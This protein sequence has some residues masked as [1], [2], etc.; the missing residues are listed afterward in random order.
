M[1]G[2][3]IPL[4]KNKIFKGTKGLYLDLVAFPMKQRSESKD[5][6]L[7]K[8]SF[9]KEEREKMSREELESLP[10]IGNMTDWNYVQ[11]GNTDPDLDSGAPIITDTELPY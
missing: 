8:Q 7:I 3:F 6:H 2:I 11:R 4:E 5:T 10:I 1:E 9:S